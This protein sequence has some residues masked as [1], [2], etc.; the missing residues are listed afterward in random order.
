MIRRR[1]P[2]CAWDALQQQRAGRVDDAF[3]VGHEGSFTACEPAAMMALA[4]LTTF[5]VPPRRRPRVVRIE[6]AADARHDLDLARLGHAGQAA[7]ELLDDAVLEAAQRIDVD[8]GRAYLI[9]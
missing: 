6:E 7:G 9:P 4:N 5:F 1:P 8:S 3:V 2:A